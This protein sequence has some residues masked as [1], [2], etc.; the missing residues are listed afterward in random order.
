MPRVS[1]QVSVLATA[2]KEWLRVAVTALLTLL[3]QRIWQRVQTRRKALEDALNWNARVDLENVQ[4]CLLT[5]V[6]L[7]KCGRIE[8]RTIMTKKLSEIFSNDYVRNMVLEAAEKT[9]AE[10]PLVCSHLRMEDRWAVLSAAQNHVSSIFGP[11]HLFANQVSSYESSW[12]VLTLIGVRTGGGRFFITPHH[13]LKTNDVGVLRIRIVLVNEQ[14]IR[15]ICS[16]DIA[17]T[18][19]LFSER[20]RHRWEIM[21]RFAEMFEKQLSRVTRNPVGT[22]DVRNQSWGNDLCGTFKRKH[23]PKVYEKLE[24]E[25]GDEETNEEKLETNNFLRIHIPVPL[26]KETKHVGP[27]DVVLYE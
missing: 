27:Q 17:E 16:G 5:A 21:K 3:L 6:N 7:E 8:K 23:D 13:R 24:V 14:E 2:R 22:L 11:Y 12:Y 19:E 9:T 1:A 10:N 20:H 26:L 15:R 25:Q 18:Q 4:A